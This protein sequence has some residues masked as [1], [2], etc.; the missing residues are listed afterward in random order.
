MHYKVE[1]REDG[2]TI[3][4]DSI[5]SCLRLLAEIERNAKKPIGV[6]LYRTEGES[7]SC[8]LGAPTT[9]FVWYPAKYE[10]VGTWSSHTD[11]PVSKELD[12]WLCG[13]HTQVPTD[14]QVDRTGLVQVVKQFLESG[15]RSSVIKWKQD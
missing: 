10:G 3:E 12:F 2:D 4:L 7:M 13:H 14:C 15:A 5:D 11:T 9:A 1:Y 6:Y 8:V